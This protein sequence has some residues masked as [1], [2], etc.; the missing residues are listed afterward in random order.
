MAPRIGTFAQ[1]EHHPWVCKVREPGTFRNTG[2]QESCR[3]EYKGRFGNRVFAGNLCFIL[4]ALGSQPYCRSQGSLKY[5]GR[6]DWTFLRILSMDF[7]YILSAKTIRKI[8]LLVST[9]MSSWQNV[10]LEIRPKCFHC[11]K[12]KTHLPE[13]SLLIIGIYNNDS[14]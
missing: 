12:V 2:A 9:L 10:H 3:R 14:N 1:K 4:M 6:N 7:R 5:G 8:T 13:Q 11:P